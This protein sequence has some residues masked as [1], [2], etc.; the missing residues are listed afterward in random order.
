MIRNSDVTVTIGRS[1]RPA[2]PPLFFLARRRRTMN[3]REK[4]TI[5]LYK[6]PIDRTFWIP[7]TICAHVLKIQKYGLYIWPFTPQQRSR[8][9]RNF[10]A[11]TSRS[12][13]QNP[14]AFKWCVPCTCTTINSSRRFLCVF[15]CVP[16]FTS[17]S[18]TIFP[19][20]SPC[21]FVPFIRLC[22]F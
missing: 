11:F 14:V 19:L 22:F 7:S 9:A 16:L 13:W 3:G 15:I 21:P 18:W 1:A 17:P 4:K 8:P 2:L 5:Q 12:H 20:S 6:T 10:I